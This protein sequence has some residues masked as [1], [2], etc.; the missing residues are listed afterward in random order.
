[1]DKITLE[2]FRRRIKAQNVSDRQHVAFK[3]PMCKTVQSL[4]SFICAGEHPEQAEKLIGFS[5]VGR[6][7]KADP[8]RKV[9]DSL[10]C[11]WSLG[12][13][14]KLHELEVIDEEG[15]AHPF[16]EVATA[17]EA[18]ALEAAIAMAEAH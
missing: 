16:F 3:C 9:P 8:P 4:K 18:Q 14:F 6:I 15:T 12:G 13:F 11:N 1:M 2:E 7:T 17:S 10:P 5:C